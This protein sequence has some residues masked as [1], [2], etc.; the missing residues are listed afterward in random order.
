MQKI[1]REDIQIISRHSNWSEDG[2]SK[3]LRDN[4][5]SDLPSLQ[6][7]LKLL[8]LSVGVSFALAGI[9]FFFAYNWEALHKSIK[10]G[11][12]EGLVVLTTLA[13]VIIKTKPLLK[14]LLLT[15]AAILVGVLYA[16]FGQVYQTGAN[17]YDFF[18]GWTIFISLWV[19]ISNFAPL[20]TIYIALI[21]ATVLL[22]AE[23]VAH[24]WSEMFV[25][26]LLFIINALFLVSFLWLPKLL[27]KTFFPVW[28]TNFLALAAVL[29]GTIG[30]VNGIFDKP[31]NYFIVLLF[32]VLCA[33]AL[34]FWYGLATRRSFY[35]AIVSFSVII[36]ISAFLLD[37]SEDAAM[38]LIVGLFIV[39]CVT[40][41]ILFLINLHKKWTN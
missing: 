20:W 5:Y 31:E 30:M 23:Q 8:F 7:F 2:V 13:A 3:A 26:A 6:K 9:V 34:G 39:T 38:L 12:M 11:L 33:Y 27:G 19:L 41:L 32:S 36:I 40:L 29:F 14:K 4:V 17:A 25:Y 22:Y 1:N 35:P 24:G 16:V 37:I 28:F 15:A 10:L 18:L 21:N